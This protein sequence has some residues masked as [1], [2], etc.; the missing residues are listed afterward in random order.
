M[1]RRPLRSLFG[2]F[3][4]VAGA[5]WG[6]TAAADLEHARQLYVRGEFEMAAS[7]AAAL[8]SVDG[9]ALAAQALLVN[10]LFLKM[11]E[12]RLEALRQ[13]HDLAKAGLE[14]DPDHIGSHLQAAG[15]LGLQARVKRSGQLAREARVHLKR[16][17]E[18]DGSHALALAALGGWH[19]EVLQRVGRFLGKIFY[20]ASRKSVLENFDRA[21]RLRP[22]LPSLRVGYAKALLSFPSRY[23]PQ[24]V[25]LLIEALALSPPDRLEAMTQV[26]GRLILEAL[27]TNDKKRLKVLLDDVPVS[28]FRIMAVALP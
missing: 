23:R 12:P 9:Y 15:A 4:M 10:A 25:G 7:Q 20:G 26:Y 27:E 17:L 13:A 3:L 16:I 2:F 19:G 8:E 21:I 22:D 11:G 14:R 28:E 24:A 6:P 5:F 1:T 18:L